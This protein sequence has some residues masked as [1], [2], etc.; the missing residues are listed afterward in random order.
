LRTLAKEVFEMFK[1]FLKWFTK[2]LLKLHDILPNESVLV[3]GIKFLQEKLDK[4][5]PR[6]DRINR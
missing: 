3:D 4:I 1:I 6:S 5:I 2:F